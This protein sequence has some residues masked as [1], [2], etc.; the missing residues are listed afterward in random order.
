[1]RFDVTMG[2]AKVWLDSSD[3]VMRH[4]SPDLQ[5]VLSSLGFFNATDVPFLVGMDALAFAQPHRAQPYL[6]D[7]RVT[8][9]SYDVVTADPTLADT[10]D[11]RRSDTSDTDSLSSDGAMDEDMDEEEARELA[12]QWFG[13]MP[14]L[15]MGDALDPDQFQTPIPS[16]WHA[17]SE[18]YDGD[19]TSDG[20]TE[21]SVLTT[22]RRYVSTGARRKRKRQRVDG[23][24]MRSDAMVTIIAAASALAFTMFFGRM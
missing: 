5:V 15:N 2:C 1:M 18:P 13:S 14:S 3:P 19:D 23:G 21:D 4:D 16:G 17:R 24:A 11:D 10:S 9:S 8:A 6:A 22:S 7:P 12:L 20:A